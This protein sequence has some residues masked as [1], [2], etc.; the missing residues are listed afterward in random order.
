VMLS[1]SLYAV[2]LIAVVLAV[3]VLMIRNP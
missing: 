3:Y 1:Q 2:M